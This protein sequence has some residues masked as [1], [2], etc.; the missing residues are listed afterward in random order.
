MKH[1]LLS[2]I[3]DKNTLIM[4]TVLD[5]IAKFKYFC[6]ISQEIILF[7]NFLFLSFEQIP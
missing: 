4:T 6:Q 5:K 7:A 3:L 2:S 1:L